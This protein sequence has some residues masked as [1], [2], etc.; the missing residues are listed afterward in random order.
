MK[1]ISMLTLKQLEEGGTKVKR[2]PIILPELKEPKISAADPTEKLAKVVEQQLESQVQSGNIMVEF[3]TELKRMVEANAMQQ[4]D[5]T[6]PPPDYVF[7][8]QRDKRGYI[9]K[10][11]AKA[12]RNK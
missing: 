7:T 12:Q 5:K 2:Q 11:H 1:T 9:E 10:I 4:I 3:L 6:S 8:V